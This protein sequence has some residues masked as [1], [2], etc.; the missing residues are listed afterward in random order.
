MPTDDP[1]PLPTPPPAEEPAETDLASLVADH[2]A[3][4]WRYLR[5]LGA[6]RG[7]ADDLTQETFL[8]AARASIGN[9]G[10]EQRG[11]AETRGYLRTVAR[12]Q[13]LMLRR[14]QRRR[15]STVSLDAAESVWAAA[16]END[17]GFDAFVLALRDCVDGLDGRPREAI[18]LSYREELGRSGIAARLG[19]KP[20]GVKTLLR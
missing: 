20:D 1:I 5:Y 17:G 14:K 12:N 16:E 9:R 10:F 3:T 15:I 11:P 7:E 4:V 18:K 19:M 13:L 6:A 2:Q 8:A